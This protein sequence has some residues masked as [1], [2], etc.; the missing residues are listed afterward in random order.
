[1][2]KAKKKAT[3]RKAK[4]KKRKK[5]QDPNRVEQEVIVAVKL[6]NLN[7]P[8]VAEQQISSQDV[9]VR[10][11]ERPSLAKQTDPNLMSVVQAVSAF[12]LQSQ[13][14]E[15]AGRGNVAGATRRLRWRILH[16]HA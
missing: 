4:A 14:I 16:R 10:Y 3:K 12:K 5:L 8:P 2:A 13:A 1:M 15:E 9:L 6:V 7:N 11:T